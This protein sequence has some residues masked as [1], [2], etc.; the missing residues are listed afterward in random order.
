MQYSNAEKRV[1]DPT[2]ENEKL[3]KSDLEA[4]AENLGVEIDYSPVICGRRLSLFQLWQVVMSDEFGGFDHVTGRKRWPE[5][6]RR[7]NYNDFRHAS[8]A[9]DIELCYS[10]LLA[11][12]EVARQQYQEL[13][14]DM[15]LTES[16]E[17][18]LIED[19]LRET[20]GRDAGR[21]SDEEGKAEAE[22]DDAINDDL[23]RS[24][25]AY[26]LPTLS[27]KRSHETENS[28]SFHKRQRVDK[29]KGREVEIPSTPEHEIGTRTW[30]P[31]N[32]TPLVPR[33]PEAE[34][35]QPS[36]TSTRA[37]VSS[38]PGSSVR[39]EGEP[40][41]QDFHYTPD[42]ENEEDVAGAEN[43][44][45]KNQLPLRH[46]PESSLMKASSSSVAQVPEHDSSMQSES[47][48]R[49]QEDLLEHIERHIA[50][51]YTDD[52]V[53]EAM[54]TTSLRIQN[55]ALVMESMTSGKGIPNDIRGVWTKSD[56]AIL[57]RGQQRD[58]KSFEA[59]LSKHGKQQIEA[60]RAYLNR[61]NKVAN[62][63]QVEDRD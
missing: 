3:F 56:D 21:F 22:V 23:D 16:Q 28:T 9:A 43:S 30:R 8:A 24:P 49:R 20:S 4:L 36:S 44:P 51:G 52:V 15:T 61:R 58:R 32:S 37:R 48:S 13:N 41:T 12:F 40:D 10:E 50:L 47:N 42:P 59:I 54:E 55:S 39:A 6:A 25:S 2:L 38:R 14:P 29:G 60:R 62:S 45:L 57:M 63:L 53:M 34:R 1:A 33:P 19:Q 31:A 46:Q 11:D 17:E 35:S 18:A 27:N 26:V 7:L 5:V